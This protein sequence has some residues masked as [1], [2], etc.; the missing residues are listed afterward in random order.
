MVNVVPTYV[1][2]KVVPCWTSVWRGK[3]VNM[4]CKH[5]Q[6]R[7]KKMSRHS[8]LQHRLLSGVL[9]VSTC[10]QDKWFCWEPCS[11][12]IKSLDTIHDTMD[13]PLILHRI[14]KLLRIPVPSQNG[15]SSRPWIAPF[16]DT[17]IRLKSPFAL[18]NLPSI[19]TNRPKTC[20]RSATLLQHF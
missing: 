4:T 13:M 19:Q 1:L 5:L 18:S 3:Q 8:C 14:S 15:K 12:R 6:K 20:S 11:C 10:L 2:L 7:S 16:L 17:G 9:G